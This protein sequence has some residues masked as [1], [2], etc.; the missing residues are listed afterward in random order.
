MKALFF[1]ILILLTTVL[2]EGLSQS[3]NFTNFRNTYYLQGDTIRILHQTDT[4]DGGQLWIGTTGRT[5][6]SYSDGLII[7]FDASLNIVWS[8][9]IGS[10]QPL[11][12]VFLNN[13]IEST[14]GGYLIAGY[15]TKQSGYPEF[16]YCLLRC[17]FLG[18]ITWQQEYAVSSAIGQW[19]KIA[20]TGVAED[21][22]AFY[23]TGVL[24]G[25]IPQQ[26]DGQF[27]TLFKTDISGNLTFS[28]L[29]HH[30][31]VP[32]N[33]SIGIYPSNGNLLL[34]GYGDDNNN[35][36]T[37][38]R[39]VYWIQLNSDDASFQSGNA[40]CFKPMGLPSVSYSL[41]PHFLKSFKTN[42]G[43]AVTG[44]I[45]E[46]SATKRAIVTLHFDNNLQL[47]KSWNLPQ[48]TGVISA[49]SGDFSVAAD[50][51][52]LLAQ[53]SS[54]ENDK[55][56]LSKYDM[57]GYIIS[58]RKVGNFGAG[59]GVNVLSGGVRI[60][61]H[62]GNI[63]YTANYFQNG[64][65]VAE[66]LNL[67]PN[68]SDTTCFGIE[69][70][71]GSSQPFE[72][73]IMPATQ[74]STIDNIVS[75]RLAVFNN[76]S[77]NIKSESICSLQTFC[78]QLSLIGLDTVCV[79]GQPVVYSVQRNHGCSSPVKWT[80]DSANCVSAK[81]L[82]DSSISIQWRNT[83]WALQTTKLIATFEDCNTVSDT[84]LV[85]L[86]PYTKRI[87]QDLS[88]CIGDSIK[89]TP[90][91][92]F[93]SYKWQD[94]SDDSIFIAKTPGFY[95]VVYET[96]CNRTLEDTVTIKP[97]YIELLPN[98]I[99]KICKGDSIVLQAKSGF[100]DYHWSP[101]Y[102][103]TSTTENVAIVSPVMDTAYIVNALVKPGCRIYDTVKLVTLNPA[104]IQIKQERR[105]CAELILYVL[106]PSSFSEI[107][108]SEPTNTNAT[109][110]TVS[111]SGWYSFTAKDNNGC[112]VKD[113]ANIIFEPCNNQISFP[114]AFTPNRDGLNDIFRPLTTGRL[115]KYE[116]SIYN[117]WGQK[118]F[119]SQNPSVG[120]DGTLS[121]KIQQQQN[122]IWICRY[123]LY[124]GKATTIKGTVLLIK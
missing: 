96:F 121:G 105:N 41:Y 117:R 43:Y 101:D 100:S 47:T 24:N 62:N 21:D 32:L 119:F 22:A 51:N 26:T 40:F 46:N 60:G 7:K 14:K 90:G 82:S 73:Y 92:W 12:S 84:L 106:P 68:S 17:D 109:Q 75:N 27:I 11:T 35:S 112:I 70:M 42:S 111:K 76:S 74:F 57:N 86:V 25:D 34:W 28:K 29:F 49:N 50:G 16:A 79:L 8:K 72:T 56:Y 15:S 20:L 69:T 83:I 107:V 52:L 33:S 23:V 63:R 93:K 55:T 99:R 103:I 39:R 54:T 66:I 44:L 67:S 65:P 31:N 81:L 77:V 4:N 5:G 89:L 58:Q 9:R 124:G 88:L 91:N 87:A 85:A 95:K 98:H 108:W 71:L 30:N 48:L 114:N 122:F 36:Q 78:S 120:W 1:S 94:G 116:L 104:D 113:S 45:A 110:L 80:F 61:I 18:N 10:T 19:T 118:I 102:R 3:C 37:D 123:Q 115:L 38:T 2:S 13:A 6:Y 53:R 59:T 64:I 97:L